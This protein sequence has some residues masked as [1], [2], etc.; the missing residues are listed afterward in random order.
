MALIVTVAC[1]PSL[2][3]S[4]SVIVFSPALREVVGMEI[5]REP[6]TEKDGEVR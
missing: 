4:C 3:D 5:G 1:A 6:T 2:P